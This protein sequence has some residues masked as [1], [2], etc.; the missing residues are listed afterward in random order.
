MKKLLVTL[1]ILICMPA[2]TAMADPAV[3]DYQGLSDTDAVAKGLSPFKVSNSSGDIY[4][5]WAPSQLLRTNKT[6][7]GSKI[8]VACSDRP[9]REDEVMLSTCGECYVYKKTR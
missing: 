4:Q 1:I 6:Y 3:P 5:C 8:L 7:T 9:L 2:G